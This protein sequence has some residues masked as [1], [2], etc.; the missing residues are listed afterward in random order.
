MNLPYPKIWPFIA[1]ISTTYYCIGISGVPQQTESQI[2][3]VLINRR[4][5]CYTPNWRQKIYS[6]TVIHDQTAS[7]TIC[8]QQCSSLGILDCSES[9]HQLR[10]WKHRCQTWSN[11]KGNKSSNPTNHRL[12]EVLCEE[13]KKHM[14]SQE[15]KNKSYKR[16]HREHTQIWSRKRMKLIHREWLKPTFIEESWGEHLSAQK[17]QGGLKDG[18]VAELIK[19]SPK[20]LVICLLRL[21]LESRRWNSYRKNGNKISHNTSWRK[22]CES[23]KDTIGRVY[24]KITEQ[25]FCQIWLK[26]TWKG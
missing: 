7:K 3:H 19:I 26:L 9:R 20:K 2:D 5:F 1:L 25:K 10:N 16:C 8:H 22:G 15:K 6:Q 4:H 12:D 18:I 21:I 14:R 24:Y 17:Q 11:I 23:R 13:I